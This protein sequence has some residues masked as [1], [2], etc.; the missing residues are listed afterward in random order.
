MHPDQQELDSRIDPEIPQEDFDEIL[1]ALLA[2]WN[3]RALVLEIPGLYLL[4]AEFF[5]DRVKAQWQQQSVAQPE[6][7][8]DVVEE[9]QDNPA[10]H[11][12]CC[13]VCDAELPK[14][15]C[16]LHPYGRVYDAMVD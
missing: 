12:W 5:R 14:G 7:W 6:N 3:T 10:A 13:A 2:D 8:P 11:E 15:H 9:S 4:V 16:A 1:F